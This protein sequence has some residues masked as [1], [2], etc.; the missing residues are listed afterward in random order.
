MIAPERW[1]EHQK[2]YQ[3]YG[4]DMKP[5]P[6]SRENLRR[7]RNR[8]IVLPGVNKRKMIFMAVLA[9]GI[10]M[11]LCIIAAAYSA[12]IRYDTNTMLR[13]NRILEGEIEN[14]QVKVYSAN[15]VAYI[16]REAKD[17]LNMKY[18]GKKNRVYITSDDIPSEGFADIIREKA[19]N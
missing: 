19:Y 17:K 13:E 18:P 11:I 1:Y 7:K 9:M 16:E 14:L 4:L 5:Q 3:R 15:N 8:K 12:D 10:A 6:E 2:N